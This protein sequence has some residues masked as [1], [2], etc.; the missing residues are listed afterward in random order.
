M[1]L[2]K[3]ELFS[4]LSHGE[5]TQIAGIATSRRGQNGAPADFD[6]LNDAVGESQLLAVQLTDHLLAPQEAAFHVLGVVSR[7]HL[8][9]V[10]QLR[11]SQELDCLGGA[12]DCRDEGRAGSVA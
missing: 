6:L 4:S 3:I 11:T 10:R 9:V 5:I 8:L 2:D 1:E 7:T 12:G